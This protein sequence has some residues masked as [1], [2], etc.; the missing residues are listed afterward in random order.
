MPTPV[1]WFR[2][3]VDSLADLSGLKIR[4]AGLG[5]KVMQRAGA[6]VTMIPGGEIY[7]A[8]EKGA[9]DAAEFSLP[10][11]DQML[12]FDRV[13]KYNYY[14]GWHQIGSANHLL[15]NL[16]DWNSLSDARRELVR[17]ACRSRVA[18]SLAEAEALQG[19]VLQGFPAKGVEARTLPPDVLLELRRITTDVLGE[20][21]A[22][23]PRFAEILASQRAFSEAYALWKRRGYLPRDF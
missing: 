5:G 16:D 22:A 8:L 11:V 19:P 14:P 20:E 2:T 15:I 6:S 18:T 7:Q 13:A 4:F 10:A 1:C 9:I 23:D 17:L 3:P 21:A 12:G